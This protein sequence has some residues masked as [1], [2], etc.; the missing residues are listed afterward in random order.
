MRSRTGFLAAALL[1]ALAL[2]ACTGAPLEPSWGDISLL[3]NNILVTFGNVMIQLN[4]VDGS[5]VNLYDPE[6]QIRT[7]PATQTARRWEITGTDATTRFYQA[8]FL[9]DEDL[10]LAPSYDRKL[11]EI[12]NSAARLVNVTGYPL[13]GH[14]VAPVLPADDLLYVPLSENDLLALNRDDLSQAWRFATRRGIW[15][16]PLL[17]D[18]TLYVTS[19]DHNL[20]AVDSVTGQEIWRLDLGGA[21]A[22]APVLHDGALYIG[23]FARKLYK[24]SLDGVILAEYSTVDWV[25]GTPTIVDDTLYAADL[26]GN[27]YALAIDGDGFVELWRQQTAAR[28]IRP[29]VVV[30]QDRVIAA[31]RD[32]FVYWLN[33]ETGETIVR[34]DVRAEVMADLLL[35][36]PTEGLDIREPL[37]LV[38]TMARDNLLF[39]FAAD[40]NSEPRWKYPR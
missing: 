13:P 16:E 34:H 35:L 9:W 14:I 37:L 39:A 2:T 21:I 29:S 5:P 15:A 3:D 31:S 12:E 25:W 4:P 19:M 23:N 36:E 27:V 32:H 26:V 24:I 17:V 33:R 7:D 10:L 22:S 11:V 30:Y 18:D 6:G 1:L 38:S 40:G 28:A 20:Y 8:P